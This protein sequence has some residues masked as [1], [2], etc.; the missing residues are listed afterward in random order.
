M[1]LGCTSLLYLTTILI[2]F[3]TQEEINKYADND[4]AT[5]DS[6][7]EV[8]APLH[9]YP[10]LHQRSHLQLVATL[11]DHDCKWDLYDQIEGILLRSLSEISTWTSW[12][13]NQPL[14]LVLKRCAFPD[15]ARESHQGSSWCSQPMDRWVAIERLRFSI[16]L[17]DLNIQINQW[18]YGLSWQ[19]SVGNFKIQKYVD[20]L[21]KR[22]R[23]QKTRLVYNSCLYRY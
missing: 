20:F 2:I 11:W 15:Y 7:S 16:C 17:N 19:V 10:D 23:P 12:E 14:I 5:Y 21:S 4:P 8:S 9:H 6:M 18:L 22:T 13:Y 1:F 3:C